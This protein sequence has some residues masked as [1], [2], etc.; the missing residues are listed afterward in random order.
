MSFVAISQQ[1]DQQL[2]TQLIT[3][4]ILVD[5][6]CAKGRLLKAAATLFKNNGFDRTTVRELA[7]AVGIQSG[8]LF[9]HYPNKQEILKQVMR[10]GILL[11]THRVK[12]ALALN[13]SVEDKLQALILCEFQAILLDTG[14][15][16]SV[17]VYEWRALNEEN[18]IHMLALRGEYEKLWLDLLTLAQQQNIIDMSPNILRRLLTGAIS[19]S[20]NWYKASGDVT[21]EQ[22]AQM[23][24][25]LA[26]SSNKA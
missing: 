26:L 15:Q 7:K 22:L 25:R 12:H 16:M 1:D 23:T 4:S 10:Q 6:T 21:L 24:L 20:I 19:W 3:D 18:Q 13:D 11:T 8:S 2:L 5:P 17:L 14:A 9:H